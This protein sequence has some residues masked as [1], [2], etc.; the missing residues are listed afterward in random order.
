MFRL[1]FGISIPDSGKWIYVIATLVKRKIARLQ[2]QFRLRI[3]G[4]GGFE[5][6]KYMFQIWLWFCN[7]DSGENLE[8]PGLIPVLGKYSAF[9]F[10]MKCSFGSGSVQ[11]NWL[12]APGEKF[13]VSFRSAKVSCVRL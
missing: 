9:R 4:T 10:R 12:P 11:K 7:P 13:V 1:P 6:K 3:K 5:S 2:V 8:L